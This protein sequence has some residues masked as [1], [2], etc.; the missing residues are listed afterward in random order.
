[1][2]LLPRCQ[3]QWPHD[4]ALDDLKSGESYIATGSSWQAPGDWSTS[5]VVNRVVSWA[6]ID[7][8]E[9]APFEAGV[10]TPGHMNTSGAGGP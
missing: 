5:Y 7:L 3:G 10:G 8:G 9:S 1:M 2:S 4:E 6:G